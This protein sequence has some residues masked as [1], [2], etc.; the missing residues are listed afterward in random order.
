MVGL[1]SGEHINREE[2]L[3][4]SLEDSAYI[5]LLDESKD[6]LRF[7]TSQN[8]SSGEL[9]DIFR[10]SMQPKEKNDLLIIQK[11]LQK[12]GLET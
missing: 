3:S 4:Q 11:I 2:G 9:R 8:S 6:E 5:V 7:T 1:K 10:A 12:K